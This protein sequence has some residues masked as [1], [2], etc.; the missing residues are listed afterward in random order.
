MIS[1]QLVQK[2]HN[3]DVVE[4]LLKIAQKTNDPLE[5]AEII[6]LAELVRTL[7]RRLLQ[8]GSGLDLKETLALIDRVEKSVTSRQTWQRTRRLKPARTAKPKPPSPS[9][10]K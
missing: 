2:L 8:S 1:W 3:A 6:T 5:R 4:P 7:H 10:T 9:S